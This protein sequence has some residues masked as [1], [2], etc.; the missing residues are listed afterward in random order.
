MRE[1]R[2][3]Q[4]I[5][6]ITCIV[7]VLSAIGCSEKKTVDATNTPAP[8]FTLQCDLSISFS[9]TAAPVIS[10]SQV[11]TSTTV[12][13]V[14]GKNGSPTRTQIQSLITELNTAG[15]DVIAPYMPW[16]GLSWNGTLCDGM[17]YINEL[18]LSEQNNENYVILLG[19]S[20]AGPIALAY[21]AL[22][23]SNKADAINVVAPGHFI[24]QSSILASEHASSIAA[25]KQ[26]ET[27]GLSDQIA[28]FQTY[29][30]GQLVDIS[31][32]AKNYLSFHDT[33][34]FPNILS[35]I[36]LVTTPT[37]WL[38]GQQDSLTTVANNLGIAGAIPT[39][40]NIYSY[41][42]VSG[43]HFTVLESVPAELNEFF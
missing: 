40:G 30:N 18:I 27:N 24:H 41:K 17:N 16:S 23:N 13:L 15:Y 28:T 35:S 32:T 26:M 3:R 14:H 42:E 1:N 43:D 36:P 39:T 37:L 22:S 11:G 4:T 5:L 10:R 19:H 21:S 7:L 34:Q 38:A 33:S 29:N 9:P 6:H 12:L 31:T 8:A 20:L 25:A 2:F